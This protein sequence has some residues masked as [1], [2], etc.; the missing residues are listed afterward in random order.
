MLWVQRI[1]PMGLPHPTECESHCLVLDSNHVPGPEVHEVYRK[2]VLN[3]HHFPDPLIYFSVFVTSVTRFGG[4]SGPAPHSKFTPL[5][6]GPIVISDFANLN[7]P[8]GSHCGRRE[9]SLAIAN[10]AW[11][12]SS[13]PSSSPGCP[14][15][16]PGRRRLA[17]C[18]RLAIVIS[19]V[20]LA[21]PS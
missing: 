19:A 13:R 17:R 3:L 16:S 7:W 5:K 1:P 11:P 10:S 2:F 9:L 14:S 8:E 6:G 20:V 15:S 21:W 18:P 12:L 4:H